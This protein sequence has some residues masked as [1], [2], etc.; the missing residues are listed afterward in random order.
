MHGIEKFFIS[1]QI[2]PQR[3]GNLNDMIFP[4]ENIYM[5]CSTIKRRFMVNTKN[6]QGYT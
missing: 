4:D 3:K 2:E 1:M 6:I 5:P